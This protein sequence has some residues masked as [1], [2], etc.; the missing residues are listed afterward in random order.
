M[1]PTWATNGTVLIT[2]GGDLSRATL[3]TLDGGQLGGG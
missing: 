3:L 2:G 1:M